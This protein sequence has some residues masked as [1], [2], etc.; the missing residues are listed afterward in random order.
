MA[1]NFANQTAEPSSLASLIANVCSTREALS[2]CSYTNIIC[3]FQ[4]SG[5]NHLPVN[6]HELLDSVAL[7][8]LLQF[9]RMPLHDAARTGY[10]EAAAALIK[11]NADLEAKAE[12]NGDIVL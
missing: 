2:L 5:L 9:G 10:R 3:S 12:V 11:S 1:E 8:S 6:P 4:K 7:N